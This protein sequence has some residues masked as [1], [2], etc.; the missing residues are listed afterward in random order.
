MLGKHKRFRCNIACYFSGYPQFM[1]R[2][3]SKKLG[4][5]DPCSCGS[6]KKYKHCCVGLEAPNINLPQTQDIQSLQLQ[7][8]RAVANADFTKAEYYYRQIHILK[9]QDA[10]ILASLGQALCWLN[11]RRE[12]L[13]Y[14][15]EAAKAVER[16]TTKT[17][18]PKFAM[19]LSSQLLHWGEINVAER[20]ARLAVSLAPDSLTALNNLVLCLTRVNRNAEALPLSQRVCQLLPDQ[21]GCTIL[22]AIIESQLG[23]TDAALERLTKV[24]ERNVEPDQTARAWLELGIILD[25]LGRYDDAFT[26]LTNAA[27]INTALL[28][29]P[30]A[31]RENIFNTLR[32]NMQDFDNAL[33][34]RWLAND[35]INDGLPAPA[36]LMGFLR[37][38]TTL[39]ERVLEAHP[40]LMTTDESSIVFELTQKLETISGIADNHASALNS[41]GT[42]QIKQLRQFYW[43]RMREEYGEQVMHKQLVDK[44]ALNTIDLGVISVVFPE[45]KILF[46]LRD[47]RDISISCFMQAFT[48]TPATVN[49]LSLKGIAKQ[50]AAVM[51]FWL[52]LRSLI[53]PAY[54]ELRYEDT[55]ADFQATY[56]GVFD[57]LGVEWLPEVERFHERA[58]GRYISTP[59]FAA[60]SQPIYSKAVARWKHYEKQLTPIM[61][62]L[63][64][65]IVAFGY[66]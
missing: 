7:A 19:D 16:Q 50:Y 33:L 11:R 2:S 55:V 52:T 66:R 12:G 20:L 42:E 32:R 14:L 34:K 44:N 57:F 65:F 64:R 41:L 51:D 63:E 4:R 61:P 31:V 5:N 1:N 22:L 58:K 3:A 47:P 56:R 27:N 62:L 26:A 13:D 30:D 37:S 40:S 18:D 54:L 8:Q 6:G 15:L 29:H 21:P 49:L 45:A 59:S 24:I 39:T 10:F 38:G 36:F 28:K 60:V 43:Q 35:L 48:L 53:Q 23:F 46:A 9:P 17:R 25:K